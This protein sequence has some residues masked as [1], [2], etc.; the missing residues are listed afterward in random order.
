MKPVVGK[1]FRFQAIVDGR[2]IGDD[3][4]CILGSAMYQLRHL[5]VLNDQRLARPS[6][7]PA[8]VSSVLR[9]DE[10][11]HDAATLSLAESL[12]GWLIHGYVYDG[13]V[14]ILAQE[15]DGGDLAGP[16]LVSVLDKAEYDPIF[17]AIHDY[18]KTASAGQ[19]S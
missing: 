17:A 12:D 4:P 9:S 1:M 15:Y 8:A 10:S 14:T 18:W 2:S 3:E 16:I 7:D 6:G 5:Q 13:Q 19:P 11:L